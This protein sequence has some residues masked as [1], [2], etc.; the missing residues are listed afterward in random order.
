MFREVIVI[1]IWMVVI[2]GC[3]TRPDRNAGM[4]WWEIVRNLF[5]PDQ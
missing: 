5:D 1:V 3:E 4:S 2:V